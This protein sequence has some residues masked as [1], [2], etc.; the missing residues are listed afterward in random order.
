MHYAV[1]GDK[2]QDR[3]RNNVDRELSKSS[4]FCQIKSSFTHYISMYVMTVIIDNNNDNRK[5]LIQSYSQV[6]AS[7][8]TIYYILLFHTGTQPNGHSSDGL[9]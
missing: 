9:Y 3:R 4:R 7:F 1:G 2:R 8:F 6:Q 5:Q